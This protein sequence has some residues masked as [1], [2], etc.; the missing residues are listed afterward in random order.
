M[1]EKTELKRQLILESAVKV[2]SEKGYKT[3]TMKDIVEASDISRGGLYLYFASVEDVFLAV[4]EMKEKAADEEILGEVLE[5][6]SGGEILLWF[7][8]S[9]KKE[10]LKKKDSLML[11]KYEY[12]FSCEEKR[13]VSFLKKEMDKAVLVLQN[14][15]ERGTEGGEFACFDPKNEARD[16]MYAIEGMKLLSLTTGISEKKVDSEFLHMMERIVIEDEE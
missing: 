5:N 14:I 1:S 10:I 8:K 9:Q 16:M 4:L 6:A 12:A 3:V 15:L 7:L 11:A 13:R 2:F